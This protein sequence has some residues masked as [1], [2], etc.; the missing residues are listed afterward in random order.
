MFWSSGEN[1]V[2]DLVM[3]GLGACHG[4][5]FQHKQKT[6][7]Y[8]EKFLIFSLFYFINT[9]FRVVHCLFLNFSTIVVSFLWF[10]FI[11]LSIFFFSWIVSS[12]F[13]LLLYFLNL[14]CEILFFSFFEPRIYRKQLLY[15]RKVGHP[16]QTPLVGSYLIFQSTGE[17]REEWAHHRPSTKQ[18]ITGHHWS[19]IKKKKKQYMTT[20]LLQSKRIYNP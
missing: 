9:I 10:F 14:F 17:R 18:C 5:K 12:Q 3:C 16:L 13:F 1:I 7:I 6:G 15:H 4:F 19:D 20:L 8:V 11:L 2:R